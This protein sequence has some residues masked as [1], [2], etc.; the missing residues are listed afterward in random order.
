MKCCVLQTVEVTV[1]DPTE[2]IGVPV[3][4]SE[5][6]PVTKVEAAVTVTRNDQEQP[7]PVSVG[8]VIKGCLEGMQACNLALR[9]SSVNVKCI[10]EQT[11]TNFGDANSF[12]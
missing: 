1:T 8:L 3:P 9:P 10:K 2:P 5:F 6:G 12:K 4:G 11:H 7:T